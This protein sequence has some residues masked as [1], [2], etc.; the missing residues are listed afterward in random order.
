MPLL[1]LGIVLLLIAAWPDG[2][3]RIDALPPSL[4]R[5]APFRAFL[6][7][8]TQRPEP[9]DATGFDLERRLARD[10]LLAS[11]TL[12]LEV[13]RLAT[14]DPSFGAGTRMLAELVR[15]TG[16]TL[17]VTH[18]DLGAT[19]LPIRRIARLGSRGEPIHTVSAQNANRFPKR[20][21]AAL[22]RMIAAVDH[23]NQRVK[24]EFPA[25]DAALQ[26]EV[27]R[28]VMTP[29]LVPRSDADSRVLVEVAQ[30]FDLE[31]L[32]EI[33]TNLAD[34]I[35]RERATLL[36]VATDPA[37]SSLRTL[38]EGDGIPRCLLFASECDSGLVLVGNRA[39]TVIP[40]DGVALAIDL[41]GDD[42]WHGDACFGEVELESA[43]VTVALD[44]AGRDKYQGT[45]CSAG[46]ARDGIALSFD[47]EG[48][49]IYETTSGGFA[50]S[51]R[52]VAITIDGRGDDRYV[53][54]ERGIGYAMFG[55][56]LLLDVS[57]DD[58]YRGERQAIGCAMSGGVAAFVDQRGMDLYTSDRAASDRGD[59]TVGSARAEQGLGAVALFVDVAGDDSFRLGRG[60]GGYAA[61]GGFAL[62][63][64]AG[65][66][67]LYSAAAWCLGSARGGGQG[68]FR[69]YEG[70]D[71]YL[72]R[73][74][75][76]GSAAGGVGIFIDDA[77]R[78]RV[79][80]IDPSRGAVAD[81]G[82]SLFIDIGST[83]KAGR[84]DDR[85]ASRR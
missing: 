64:D 30:S 7:Q 45:K 78:D 15:P 31:R 22:A 8:L 54:A 67:D 59:G 77:E 69:D 83:A 51:E 56:S 33:A 58:S 28:I 75:S 55:A 9:A 72:A 6:A 40:L 70:V 34:A 79:L 61:L 36:E 18:L 50:S 11:E 76:L 23:A 32:I 65:G 12:D 21:A 29:I 84:A 49:D 63:V 24:T 20:F 47:A 82:S 35:D 44:L 5:A 68:W 41:G 71:E 85:K 27:R 66:D 16:E 73:E 25:A 42:L 48:D 60:A 43:R 74:F 17:P 14:L 19:E 53:C 2:F 1:V 37:W 81:G 26:A 52:G 80:S 3:F 38:P 39:A 4:D 62:C 13:R 46:S 10:P 57:G